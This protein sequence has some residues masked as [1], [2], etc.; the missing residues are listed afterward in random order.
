MSHLPLAVQVGLSSTPLLTQ[1]SERDMAGRKMAAE[2]VSTRRVR[3][4]HR[5]IS[6]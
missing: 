4:S 5:A 1:A 2:L 3:E 6:R